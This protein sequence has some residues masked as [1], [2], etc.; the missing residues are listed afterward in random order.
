MLRTKPMNALIESIKKR[1]RARFS[2]ARGLFLLLIH[3][4]RGDPLGIHGY[5]ASFFCF[6][7]SLNRITPGKQGEHCGP[8]L[9]K[10][11]TEVLGHSLVRTLVCSHRSFVCLLAHI[12]YSLARGTVNESMAIY[13]VFF[14]CVLASL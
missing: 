5:T 14:K 9:P 3:V 10:V 13:S 4:A 7:L 1:K 6:C 11:K 12:A 8:E 2:W